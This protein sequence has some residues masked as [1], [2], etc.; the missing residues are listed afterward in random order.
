M[1]VPPVVGLR[2]Y[3]RDARGHDRDRPRPHHH[4]AAPQPRCGGQVRRVLRTRD[5]LGP[6]REPGHHRQ[7]DARVRGD[8]HH[9]PDR[10][11]HHLVPA[12][13]RARR[14]APRAGRG[15]RQGAGP[16]ARGRRR[17]ADVHRA[18]RA[19]PLDRRAQPGRPGPSPGPGAADAA[20]PRHSAPR[21]A[22]T[23][24]R[25][26][27]R[28]R[29][30]ATGPRR[31]G[32]RRRHRRDHQLHQHLE[33]PGHGGRR[34]AGQAG[35]RARPLG[36]AVGEDLARPRLA[37][38]HGLP[39][40]GRADRAPRGARLLPRRLRLHDL[41]RELRARSSRASP[42]RCRAAISPSPPCSRATGTSRAASTPTSG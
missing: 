36:Q 19:R 33:P 9:L 23:E 20:P 14:G 4:S 24:R 7:H 18:R 35:R 5:R 28:P 11:D 12:L 8:L 40:A 21:S 25:R 32:R 38:G 41:H 6:G 31:R 10:R 3:G 13:H 27:A 17:R 15:L 2:L 1:L 26:R 42:R 30:W 29:G 37:G 39:R 22:T 34:P 16:V